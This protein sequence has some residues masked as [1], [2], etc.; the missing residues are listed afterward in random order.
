MTGTFDD[1]A[2]SV[3][4]DRTAKG[5]EK[6]VDLPSA[7]EKVIYKVSMASSQFFVLVGTEDFGKMSA[8]TPP[9]SK[10]PKKTV[11]SRDKLR[12]VRYLSDSGLH[13]SF[14]P[15]YACVSWCGTL[16]HG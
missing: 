16:D 8:R 3:K 4:L 14:L 7:E 10:A 11:C 5:F 6:Y 9:A 12:G 1:W 2:K 13:L 15:L